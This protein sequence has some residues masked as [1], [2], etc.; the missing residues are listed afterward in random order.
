MSILPASIDTLYVLIVDRSGSMSSLKPATVNGINT[1]L[2]TQKEKKVPNAY[3]SLYQF[4]GEGKVALETTFD[5]VPLERTRMLGLEDFNPRGGTPL[6][7]AIGEIINMIRATVESAEN[8]P[9]V[10][11]QIITD[12]GDTEYG[13]G[14]HTSLSVSAT[15]NDLEKNVKGWTFTYAGANHDAAAFAKGLGISSGNTIQYA[16]AKMADTFSTMAAASAVYA[17]ASASLRS[18]DKKAR[19]TTESLY[20]DAGLNTES[21]AR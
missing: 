11:V 18:M 8:P 1:Y 10:I 15:I 9:N 6:F 4:D 3:V 21:L 20:Q 19:F 2:T 14:E 12:G 13:R 16:N 7:L 5:M 17:T